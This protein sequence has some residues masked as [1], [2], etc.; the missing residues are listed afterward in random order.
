MLLMAGRSMAFADMVQL[1]LPPVIIHVY[2]MGM[3]GGK[4]A[5]GETSSG[6]F[7]ALMLLV[8]TLATIV[9]APYYS[10]APVP[11]GGGTIG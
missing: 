9:L 4:I 6:F 8:F 2:M 11:T 3:V 7:H 10:F 1:L 5:Y